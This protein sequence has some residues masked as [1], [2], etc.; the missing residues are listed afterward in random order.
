[1]AGATALCRSQPA[2]SL[3]IK[4]LEELVDVEL[5][6]RLPR[7]LTHTE[8]SRIRRRYARELLSLDDEA[9]ARLAQP[10]VEGMVRL[11]KLYGASGAGSAVQRLVE[12]MIRR[13]VGLPSSQS[14][15][16]A[17]G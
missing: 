6:A 4:R 1:M 3:Q 2:V 17:A 14:A 11:E 8:E 15:Q 16:P 12:F 7:A 10:R 13:L 5:F 9:L